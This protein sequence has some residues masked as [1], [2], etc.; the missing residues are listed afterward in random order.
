MLDHPPIGLSTSPCPPHACLANMLKFGTST[1]GFLPF[2]INCARLLKLICGTRCHH[3]GQTQITHFSILVFPPSHFFIISRGIPCPGIRTTLLPAA[4]FSGAFS[5]Q[6][7]VVASLLSAISD[8]PSHVQRVL[9]PDEIH[10][11]SK[12]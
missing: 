4:D 11:Q 7:E 8:L 6:S 12:R 10:K 9:G 2:L 5:W 1:V 3:S